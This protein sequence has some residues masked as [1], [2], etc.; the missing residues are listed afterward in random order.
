MQQK[1]HENMFAKRNGLHQRAKICP[2][3]K[4]FY[5]LVCNYIR[6]PSN[7]NKLYILPINYFL[8]HLIE[9]SH[10]ITGAG[11]MVKKDH[12]LWPKM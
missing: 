12:G 4:T 11:L 10:W 6:S 2:Y 8:K 3:T 5:M 9:V 7:N 1:Y